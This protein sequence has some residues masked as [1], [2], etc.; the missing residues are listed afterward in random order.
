MTQDTF[1]ARCH[2]H[3]L[4]E[5]G[6]I[7]IGMCEALTNDMAELRSLGVILTLVGSYAVGPYRYTNLNDAMAEARKVRSSGATSSQ[8]I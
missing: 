4:G 7:D 1:L 3:I 5:D 6:R 2:P 8:Q